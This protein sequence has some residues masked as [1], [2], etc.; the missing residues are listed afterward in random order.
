MRYNEQFIVET[1]HLIGVI[2]FYVSY[3]GQKALQINIYIYIYCKKACGCLRME[4]RILSFNL[5]RF[6]LHIVNQL[7]LQKHKDFFFFFFNKRKPI[8]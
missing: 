4:R 6:H 2:F 1:L 7:M 8:K 5:C 3:R